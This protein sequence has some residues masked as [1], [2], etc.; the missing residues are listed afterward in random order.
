[1]E[2]SIFKQQ[3]NIE[4]FNFEEDFMED[5]MRCIPMVVRYKLDKAGIKLKLSEWAKFTSNEKLQMALLACTDAIEIRT[6]H[7][8][9]AGLIERHTNQRP[10]IL[11]VEQNPAWGNRY[12]VPEM[13]SAKAMGIHKTISNTQWGSLS[14]LQR[15]ALVKL[16]RSSHENRNFPIALKEFGVVQ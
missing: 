15:F 13:V 5:G 12:N 6:Y 8:F 10:T 16:C 9:V 1:M 2:P 14:T 4:Y 11:A 7:G 3:K